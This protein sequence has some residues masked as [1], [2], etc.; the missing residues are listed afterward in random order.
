VGSSAAAGLIVPVHLGGLVLG[1]LSQVAGQTGEPIGLGH[2]G[3]TLEDGFALGQWVSK[4]QFAYQQGRVDPERSSRLEKL[5]GW[6]WTPQ[7]D[8]WQ[9]AYNHLLRFVRGSL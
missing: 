7:D 6:S 3:R 5:P 9:D 1:L 8:R 4:R 2:A